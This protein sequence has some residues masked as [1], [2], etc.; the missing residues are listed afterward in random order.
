MGYTIRFDVRCKQC[1]QLL[2]K[3]PKS[4]EEIPALVCG[5]CDGDSFEA[6][7]CPA[8]NFPVLTWKELEG[9]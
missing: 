2:S 6:V 5:H 7:E 9:K 8:Y 4:D 3:Q 1:S